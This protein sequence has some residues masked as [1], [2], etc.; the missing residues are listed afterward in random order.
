MDGWMDGW[1]DERTDKWMIYIYSFIYPS[2]HPS[3]THLLFFFPLYEM[4]RKW[5]RKR[6]IMK[7][8]KENTCGMGWIR[9]S[10]DLYGEKRWL[11]IQKIS[12]TGILLWKLSRFNVMMISGGVFIDNLQSISSFQFCKSFYSHT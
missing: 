11:K 9:W 4:S 2:I 10:K 3:I 5:V 6:K 1:M 8:V 7:S 12:K